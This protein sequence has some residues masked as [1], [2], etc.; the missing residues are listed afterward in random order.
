MGVT[1]GG[2]SVEEICNDLVIR[3]LEYDIGHALV[4]FRVSEWGQNPG[5]VGVEVTETYLQRKKEKFPSIRKAGVVLE[6]CGT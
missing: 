5:I 3:T 6:Y 2:P 4:M 1:A